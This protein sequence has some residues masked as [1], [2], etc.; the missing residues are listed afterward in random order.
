M[1]VTIS[2]AIRSGSDGFLLVVDGHF[3]RNLITALFMDGQQ[4]L[5]KVTSIK[6]FNIDQDNT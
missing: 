3:D 6:E 4:G 5:R 1:M 2:M